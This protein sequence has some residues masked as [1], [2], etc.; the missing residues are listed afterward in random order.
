M[1]GLF[2][3]GVRLVGLFFVLYNFMEVSFAIKFIIVDFEYYINGTYE[4]YFLPG[5]VLFIIGIVLFFKPKII[6]K[7][8]KIEDSEETIRVIDALK[9]LQVGL[10]LLGFYFL[11]HNL[12]RFLHKVFSYNAY[13]Y[14]DYFTLLNTVVL[15][16]IIFGLCMFLIYKSD[17]I[18]RFLL[19]EKE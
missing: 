10:I 13:E 8:L 1:R 5:F 14:K 17:K 19:L 2:E 16:I 6:S 11:S 4:M 9:V 3:I 7:K 12:Y 18:A 15:H